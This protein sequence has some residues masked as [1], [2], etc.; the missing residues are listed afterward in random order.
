MTLKQYIS[1]ILRSRG[2]ASFI[3]RLNDNIKILDVGCGNSSPYYVKQIKP[4]CFYT[5][6]DVCNYMQNKPN[7]AD[8]Y[9]I[10]EPELFSSAINDLPDLYDAVI[11]SHNLEHCNDRVATLTAI[12]KKIN[13]GGFLYLSFPCESSIKFPTRSGTLNYF[14]DTTHLNLPPKFN[15]TIEFLVNNNFKILFSVRRYKPFTL[16][17]IGMFLEIFSRHKKRIYLGT[18]EFYGFESIIW[19]EKI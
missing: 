10:V 16:F 7:L 4:D 6:V 8:K 9:I 2:K 15:Q 18:W 17:I 5:G 19:A 3:S 14:D 13:V 11:S 1:I 12:S